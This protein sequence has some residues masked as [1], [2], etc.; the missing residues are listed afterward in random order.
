MW[1]KPKE[2][3]CKYWQDGTWTGKEI[4]GQRAECEAVCT[5]L[6]KDCGAIEMFGE[7]DNMMCKLYPKC[8]AAADAD[9]T[10]TPALAARKRKSVLE[11]GGNV[12][13]YKIAKQPRSV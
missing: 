2:G 6:G 4:C 10:V 7:W 13:G 5:R 1:A 12:Q 11:S 9:F 8:E 3:I